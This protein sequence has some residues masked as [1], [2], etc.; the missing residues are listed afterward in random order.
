MI[1]RKKLIAASTGVVVLVTSLTVYGMDAAHKKNEEKKIA[2]SYSA[3]RNEGYYSAIEK[4]LVIAEKNNLNQDASEEVKRLKSSKGTYTVVEG[5]TLWDIANDFGTSPEELKKINNLSVDTLKIGTALVL[6]KPVE[7]KA[8]VAKTQK[9]NAT[10]IKVASRGTNLSQ[11]TASAAKQKP[12]KGSAVSRGASSSSKS[13][14]LDWWTEANKAF[15]IGSVAKVIDVHTGKSF[16]VKRTFG[17]NHADC[18]ALTSGD[19]SI[20]KSI[21]GGWTWGRRPVVVVV[22]STRIAASMSSMPH[23]GVDK[24]PALK[25]VSGRSEGYGTGTNLDVVKGNGMDGHFDIHFLNSTRHK[26]GKV[27]NEHQKNIRQAVGK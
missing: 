6:T 24:Y 18:E 7:S 20:I 1:N 25:T 26:D 4:Q 8:V 17:S 14:A 27:D 5:D 2:E 3:I 13:V 19:S 22:G 23:A 15:P 9:S 11:R 21:W 10:V 16:N 12:T